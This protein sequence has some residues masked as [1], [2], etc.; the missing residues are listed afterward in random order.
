MAKLVYSD[1]RKNGKVFYAT[2][3]PETVTNEKEFY[4][5]WQLEPT[6]EKVTTFQQAAAKTYKK[7]FY[8]EIQGPTDVKIHL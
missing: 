1:R 7:Y 5:P 2:K 3:D 6:M 8:L 4:L